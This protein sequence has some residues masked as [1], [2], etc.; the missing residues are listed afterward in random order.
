MQYSA[1]GL[2]E[3]ATAGW[4]D[5][6]EEFIREPSAVE[7]LFRQIR[8]YMEKEAAAAARAGADEVA[9]SASEVVP[10]KAK[11]LGL[12]AAKVVAKNR[13]SASGE[14]SSAR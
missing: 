10:S 7:K 6:D 13:A 5:N 2:G 9:K 1:D 4:L 8:K 3:E 12:G 11:G 14:E